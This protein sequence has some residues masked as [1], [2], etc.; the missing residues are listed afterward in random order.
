MTLITA[1][2]INELINNLKFPQNL[3]DLLIQDEEKIL[4]INNSQQ[5]S[6]K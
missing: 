2:D 5:S 4:L 3:E 6:L 1:D